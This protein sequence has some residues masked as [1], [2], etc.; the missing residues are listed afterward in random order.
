MIG[1]DDIRGFSHLHD[2]VKN[3]GKANH[4][5]CNFWES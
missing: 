5:V 3:G 1:F 2:S 4:S